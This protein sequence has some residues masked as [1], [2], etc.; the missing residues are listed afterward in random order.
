MI[1][2]SEIVKGDLFSEDVHYVAEAIYDDG[3]DFKHLETGKIVTLDNEYIKLL[4]PANQ[5]QKV[6]KVG[7]EDKRWTKVKIDAAIKRGTYTAEN[8]P[9]IDSIEVE[10]IRTIFENIYTGIAFKA[11]FRKA[12]E[13]LT[14]KDFEQQKSD[15][16][17][18]ALD[19][20]EK[21]KSSKK[22]M[23]QAYSTAL[24]FIQNNPITDVKSGDS[25]SLIG[26]KVQYKSRDGKYMCNEITSDSTL[27][28][29]PVNI[30][31]LQSLIVDGIKYEVVE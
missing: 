24:E 14:K 25:R 20:I 19:L 9:V 4:K 31:T 8:A 18:A 13:K 15:Q 28:Q 3:V 6:V 22:S 21:A 27:Q 10:G 5:F 12:D 26:Y 11:V 2:K 30:N 23:Q 16:R 7:K 1:T 29:R 17:Q